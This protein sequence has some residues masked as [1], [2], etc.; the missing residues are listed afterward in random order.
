M[1]RRTGSLSAVMPNT[2]LYAFTGHVFGLECK[3]GFHWPTAIDSKNMRIAGTFSSDPEFMDQ[4]ELDISQLHGKPASGSEETVGTTIVR[5]NRTDELGNPIGY[6]LTTATDW[7]TS[8]ENYDL[9]D[10]LTGSS[11]S[12]IYGYSQNTSQEALFN[13]HGIAIGYRH[14][15]ES[16]DDSFSDHW[17][18]IYDTD[19][20]L[21]SST[22][23][24]SNGDWETIERVLPP[25]LLIGRVPLSHA[26]L[27][28]GAWADG[29]AYQRTE[30]FNIN[31]N[32]V[33]S[34]SV[35]ADGSSELYSL[36]PVY[37][38]NGELEGYQGTWTWT[39]QQGETTSSEWSDHFDAEL[40]P[41][42]NA[43]DFLALTKGLLNARGELT[44]GLALMAVSREPMAYSDP[45]GSGPET[46]DGTNEWQLF[47]N[48]AANHSDT[49]NGPD[50]AIADPTD[51]DIINPSGLD[52]LTST[53]SPPP[54]S[55]VDFEAQTNPAETPLAI[56]SDKRDI[57]LNRHKYKEFTHATLLGDSDLIL[58]GNRLSNTLVGNDGSN[59]I[60]G[61]RGKDLISGGGG[62]D[63]F[64]LRNQR[65]SYDTITDFNAD[66]DKF[67][68]KGKIFRD[69][70]TSSGL[71]EKVIGKRLIFEDLSSKLWFVPRGDGSN[72]RPIKLAVLAGLEASEFSSDL[73]VLG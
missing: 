5:I 12:D 55:S 16:S 1:R 33:R 49:E 63:L 24:N 3:T 20:N 59:R 47:D 38:N 60:D 6:S 22:Y 29:S 14:T 40:N 46:I 8:I 53:S 9:D 27:V 31:G 15:S 25:D 11:Y 64:T 67:S 10:N 65:R 36:A 28:S 61:G 66:E 73:F 35:F 32:L 51:P 7:D 62:A 71:D 2:Q 18:E 21:L 58:R 37:G 39:D 68:L 26:L 43:S 69:L 70:F 42:Y 57:K 45:T 48:E 41:V 54:A 52:E 19:D 17:V 13:Q 50:G 23:S 56:T 44:T 72:S 4:Q 30:L 34:E